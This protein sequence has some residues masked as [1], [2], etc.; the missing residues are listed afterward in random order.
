MYARDHICHGLDQSRRCGT[1]CNLGADGKAVAS[2]LPSIH[3]RWPV[4]DRFAG[5]ARL[6]LADD[7]V[8]NPAVG[9]LLVE[10]A[11]R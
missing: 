10:A 9:Q 5:R 11:S 4:F 7:D 3:A 2:R 1:G 6:A 8:P